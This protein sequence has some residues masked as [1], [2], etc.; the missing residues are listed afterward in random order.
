MINLIVLILFLFILLGLAYLCKDILSPPVIL[1]VSWM[2]PFLWLV[3]IEGVGQGGF[4]INISALFFVVGLLVFCFGYFLVN[5]KT[6]STIQK[7]EIVDKK[8]ITFF[9][10]IIII[11]ELM[12]TI[13]FV[14][15]VARF[16][17]TNFQY[18]FWFTYKWNVSQGN[19]QDLFIIPY[20]RTASRVFV[21]VMFVQ[22][23]Q[24]GH[25]K[26]DTKW[27]LLQLIITI[28]LNVLGKGRGGIFSFVIPLGVIFILM[29][30]K[31]KA[32][33][34]KYGSI[35][36]AVLLAVFI[37]IAN[38]KSPY[39]RT[40]SIPVTKTIE[41][42]LCGSVVAF[43]DW[44]KEGNHDYALGAYTFRFFLAILQGLGADVNVVS[45][46]EPYVTNLN[47]NV[48][49]VYTFYKW[50]ANDFGLVYALIWQFIIGMIHG[51]ITKKT[52]TL[53][54]QKWL[55]WYALSFYPL[56]MQFFMDE[57]ITMLSA[58]IQMFF[59]IYFVFNTKLFYTQYDG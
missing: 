35:M 43:C 50:Y 2:I 10:K 32:D 39:E 46:V 42:Y 11:I 6:Y 48:G 52:F 21:C 51:Y 13:Y 31:N 19:Y 53:R 41:N 47:D 17:V 22:L 24:K 27:F 18:N 12:F 56:V 37:I 59:I 3:S 16:I 23:L 57:Y 15:D 25:Y 14:Y 55:I 29:R 7:I 33:V 54:N 28:V 45:M 1:T 30:R 40:E 44:M 8:Q 4:D 20:L 5:R 58:W 38:L 9:F 26:K 36:I 34:I 49:N